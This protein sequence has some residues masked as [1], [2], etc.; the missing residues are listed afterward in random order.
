MT[1]GEG[2]KYFIK[3]FMNKF[4]FDRRDDR[5]AAKT[6][7]NLVI[8]IISMGW[9]RWRRRK[10]GVDLINAVVSPGNQRR[11]W[12]NGKVSV[13]WK[14]DSAFRFAADLPQSVCHGA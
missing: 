10:N 8:S 3:Y 9:F 1:A 2:G 11:E 12:L 7:Q 6:T 14:Y 13:G 4:L 5:L